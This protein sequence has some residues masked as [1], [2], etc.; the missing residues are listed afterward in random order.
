MLSNTTNETIR[1][2]QILSMSLIIIFLMISSPLL[3]LVQPGSSESGVTETAFAKGQ[4]I[5]QAPAQSTHQGGQG[6]LTGDQEYFGLDGHPALRDIMWNDAGVSSGIILDISA[7]ESVIPS[8]STFLEE[9]NKKDHDN[10]GINDLDDLDD[11]N[12]GIYDLLERFDGC[13]GTDP[14][15]HDNDGILDHLD[16]DDDNDGIIEGPLNYA[17]LEALGLDPRNVTT[18]R[19]L[20]ASIIH[21]WTGQPVGAF[22]LAD[23]NPYDHDN[24]GVPDEDNDGSGSGSYDEDDDNDARIDQFKWPCDLDSD[25][26]QDYFDDDDDDDGILDIDDSH[27]YDASITTSHVEAGNMYDAYR[28]WTFNEY[29]IY[30]GGIDYIAYE[31]ARVAAAGTHGETSGFGAMGAEGTPSFTTIVDGDLDGD[32]IPNFID[33][34]NDNDGTPDSSDTDDDNDGILDMYDPDDDNDGIPDVCTNID[35]NGDGLNDYTMSNLLHHS[36][37][38]VQIQTQFPELIVKLIMTMI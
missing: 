31:A 15:D 19:Y 22:Y 38:L 11:D 7:L 32:G 4:L 12:D 36:K 16:W 27:P 20:D 17:A 2:R 13:Y 25:G 24:D 1:R 18:D 28:T 33:P 3:S 10:D 6:G 8:Y 29:R 30:S 5:G 21:P 37:H 34:D 14:Y 23:Q 26:L 9:S 35:T